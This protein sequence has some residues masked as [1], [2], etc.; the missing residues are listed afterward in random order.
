MRKRFLA[1][2]L[3]FTMTI[4]SSE[5][6]FAAGTEGVQQSQEQEI[7]TEES[8]GERETTSD[9]TETVP[10][11]TEEETEEPGQD[12]K[13]GGEVQEVQEN[14]SEVQEQ[15]ETIEEPVPENSIEPQAE[16]LPAEKG[17]AAENSL[18]ESSA[19]L[20]SE[21]PAESGAEMQAEDSGF[22]FQGEPL[23]DIRAVTLR[24]SFPMK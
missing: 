7:Y 9:Q 23:P 5:M 6:I 12:Y 10:E 4:N 20:Q 3:A 8:A 13:G 24:W 11:E 17:N 14:V 22:L 1:M 18:P 16:M 2:F 21:V 19:E 15:E